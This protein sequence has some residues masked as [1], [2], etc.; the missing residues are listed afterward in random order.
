MEVTH[1]KKSAEVKRKLRVAAY[2]R[3]STDFEEQENSLENQ[4]DHY[5]KLIKENPKYEYAGVYHDAGISGFKEKRP[6][7][8]SMMQDAR[9]GKIDLIITKSITRFAR[10]TDTILKATRELKEL[11]I[12]VF[13]ELQGI[14]TL[15]Q[16]GELMMTVYAACGQGESET[17]RGL[18]KMT[19]KRRVEDCDPEQ[20]LHRT[21]GFGMDEKR[22]VYIVREEAEIIKSIFKWVK[23]EY[24][25]SRILEFCEEN[26]YRNRDGRPFRFE[27]I[28]QIV[29]N[30]SYK[31]DYEMGRHYIDETRRSR[32]NYGELPVYYIEEDHPAIVTRSLWEKAN[33][34]IDDRAMEKTRHLDLKPLTNE[35]YPYK[36]HL[37]CGMCGA[38]L[39]GRKTKTGAQYSYSCS[40]PHCDGFS[41]P[42]K[43][44]ESWPEIKEDIYIYF[45]PKKPVPKQYR[46]VKESTWKKG[47]V[48]RKKA[49]MIPYTKE[50]YPYYKRIFCDACGFPLMRNRRADG[51]IEF[52]CSGT[53][54]Y[55]KAFCPGIHIP[56]EALNRLPETDGVYLIKEEK[57]NGTKH[58]SYTCKDTAPQRKER[59][60]SEQ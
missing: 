1:I 32:V 57:I 23:E 25:P 44:I 20:Q 24:L 58:Y 49:S 26:G 60:S 14:N 37:Y 56:E 19:F 53:A 7:F 41:I 31:G 15:T 29:R 6:G 35:N 3:V 54:K 28:Y 17:Y 48:K 45:D 40:Q 12:G 55:H 27:Q 9:S 59:G 30:V 52:I 33:K 34:V 39:I 16:A 11:G 46:Y 43:V 22:R 13:F 50:N 42:Q 2:C 36:P 5:E 18:A 8:Q 4:V 21:F 10:N 51:K 47:H 38:R